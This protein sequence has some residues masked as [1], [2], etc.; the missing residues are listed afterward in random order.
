MSA[1]PFPITCAPFTVHQACTELH[2]LMYIDSAFDFLAPN[3]QFRSGSLLLCS[4]SL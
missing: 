3:N 1:K 4:T 2:P